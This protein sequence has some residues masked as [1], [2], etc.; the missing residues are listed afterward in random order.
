MTAGQDRISRIGPSSKL[1]L[2]LLDFVRMSTKFC[3]RQHWMAPQRIFSL[4]PLLLGFLGVCHALALP[5]EPS[6]PLDLR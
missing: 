5:V 6:N 4:M 1:Y 3:V 2:R